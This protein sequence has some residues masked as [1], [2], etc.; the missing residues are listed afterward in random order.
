MCIRFS[1]QHSIVL[2]QYSVTLHS[3]KEKQ[4]SWFS[5]A[6]PLGQITQLGL[7]SRGSKIF[8]CPNWFQGSVHT[9]Y[10]RQVQCCWEAAFFLPLCGIVAYLCTSQV[11]PSFFVIILKP[12][13]L[14]SFGKDSSKTC[15]WGNSDWPTYMAAISLDTSPCPSISTPG[16]QRVVFFNQH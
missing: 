5:V 11:F 12:V 10:L 15:G 3:D 1:P 16:Q 14:W 6:G 13:L 4:Q 8:C 2:S 7:T 9:A